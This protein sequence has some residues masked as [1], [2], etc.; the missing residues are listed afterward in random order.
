MPALE[1]IYPTKVV[2]RKRAVRNRN[3]KTA[4]ESEEEKCLGGPKANNILK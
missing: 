2:Q 3:R 4:C 1:I